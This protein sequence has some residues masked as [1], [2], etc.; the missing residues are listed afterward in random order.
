MDPWERY[1]PI[2]DDPEAFRA[3]CDRPLPTAVRV[4]QLKATPE[5]TIAALEAE[6][7]S[8]EQAAW[9]PRTLLLDTDYPG[10]TWPYQHGWIHGQEEISQVPATILDPDPTDIIWDV[11]AAPGGKATQLAAAV[12]PAGCVFAN[13]VNLG[14]LTA[15]RSNADRLGIAN[16][17]VTHRDAREFTLDPF[18]ID[19][20]D[21]ALVDAPC[22]GEGTIRKN[23]VVTEDWEESRL[24]GIASLQEAMLKRAIRL[25]RPGGTVVYSTCTFAP[26]EN[27]EVLAA[28]LKTEDCA[29]TAF[30]VGLTSA[31]GVTEWQGT[32][33]PDTMRHVKRFYPH[34]NDT[35]GF[36]CAK[37]EVDG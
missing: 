4:N 34:H 21:G 32:A 6:G 23:P 11:A 22:S 8:V 5:R 12:D 20:L 14:R 28:V 29:L 15:L 16:M 30:D 10:R 31:P 33:Y 35:G 27:E 24:H 18:E 3:A 25:T 2:L 13:D 19:A 1:A 36:V 7:V 37:L 17:V 26:E 9:H